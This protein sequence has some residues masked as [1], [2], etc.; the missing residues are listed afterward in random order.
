MADRF[1]AQAE[2]ILAICNRLGIEPDE[3]GKEAGIKPETMRKY[4]KGYQKASDN[5]MQSLRNV[6]KI[7][8]VFKDSPHK[9]RAEGPFSWMAT[10]T[11]EK[12]LDDLTARL[13][14]ASQQERRHV[15]SNIIDVVKEIE[16]RE[17]NSKPLSE[18]QRIAKDAGDRFDAEH[19]E[20]S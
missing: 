19:A 16:L 20:K 18:A 4:A 6:E 8:A 11:L 9:P 7:R 10:P 14:T 12:T 5:L 1:T 15:I 17:I 13:H 2:E 3:L